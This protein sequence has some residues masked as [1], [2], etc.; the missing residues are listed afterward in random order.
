MQES[1]GSMMYNTLA[2]LLEKVDAELAE[3]YP[4]EN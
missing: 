4:K 2:G 1:V 3:K